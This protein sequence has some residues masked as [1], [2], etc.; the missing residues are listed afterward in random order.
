MRPEQVIA[1]FVN[2][3]ICYYV[4]VCHN[5]LYFMGIIVYVDW[6]KVVPECVSSFIRLNTNIASGILI[7]VRID[8][9]LINVCAKS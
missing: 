1:N 5:F 9:F 2:V 3:Y 8:S 6:I 7:E 4:T